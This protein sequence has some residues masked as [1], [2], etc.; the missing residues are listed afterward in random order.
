MI[1][2]ARDL[3]AMPRDNLWALADGQKRIKVQMDDGL[4]EAGVK[5]TIISAYC[6]R[7]Y[8]QY[9]KTPALVKHQLD[10]SRFNVNSITDL[11]DAVFWDCRDAYGN[12]VDMEDLETLVGEIRNEIYNDVTYRLEAYAQPLSAM[13][14]IDTIA[15]PDVKAI[16]DAI[17]PNQKSIDAAHRQIS[18]LLKDPTKMKGNRIAMG[19]QMGLYKIGQVLQMVSARGY[20]TDYDNNV[21]RIP[22][23]RGFIKGFWTI[24]D[25]AKESRSATKSLSFTED[26][27]Q[28]SQYFNRKL[29]LLADTITDLIPGDCGSSR[30]MEW[31]VAPEDV[32]VLDGMYYQDKDGLHAFNSNTAAAKGLI[33]KTLKFRTVFYCDSKH[34]RGFCQVC[35]GEMSHSIVRGTA[36]GHVACTK[37]GERISQIILSTKHDDRN[38]LGNMLNLSRT[39][40]QFIKF[41]EDRNVIVLS[42]TLDPKKVTITLDAEEAGRLADVL[43]VDDVNLLQISLVSS[44]RRVQFNV[45]TKQGELSAIVPVFSGKRTA[46]AS[47]ELLN[48]VKQHRWELTPNGNY[49]IDLKDWDQD[50]ALFTLPLKNANMLDYMKTIEA[51]LS[52]DKSSVSDITIKHCK[53]PDEALRELHAIVSTQ[54][55]INLVYLQVLVFACMIRSADNYDYRLPL[56]GNRPHF[57]KLATLIAG[58]SMVPVL[59]YQHQRPVL[60][61]PQTF[62]NK[63][64]PNHTLDQVM[65]LN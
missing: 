8:V 38:A 63:H 50:A 13:D 11:I 55:K 34:P 4:I 16:N 64:R 65:E 5:E 58:R 37:I 6:W 51:F 40:Q 32:E 61:E 31:F 44:I 22:I 2:H 41:I 19:T 60:M 53:T 1:Y 42:D 21:F 48:Y 35:F 46:S 39:D 23:T 43:Y 18:K 47:R 20:L 27:L 49:S 3:A 57:A 56:P 36:P 29:Q 25:I 33:G 30:L 45:K 12:S 10:S 62:L 15:H 24:E 14:L 7:F 54:L 59:A 52:G 17:E 26:P 9:P 28:K